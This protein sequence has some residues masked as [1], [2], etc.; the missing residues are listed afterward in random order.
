M[1]I[2]ARPGH[3]QARFTLPVAGFTPAIYAQ[4]ETVYRITSRDEHF[5]L[6]T[7][8]SQKIVAE[9]ASGANR[10]VT[11]R[12]AAGEALPAETRA[13]LDAA[14]Q[15]TR[16]LN[17]TEPSVRAL[18]ARF[19]GNGSAIDAIETFVDGYITN[20]TTGIPLAT[21]SG[22]IASR[23]GDCTEHAVLAI[24][25][26]RGIGIPARGV[27]GMILAP[28]FM[29]EENVF[30]YHM[31][32]EAY[33]QGR[34]VL[35]DATRPGKKPLNRYVAFAYH[36]LKSELPVPVLKA[37]AAIREMTVTYVSGR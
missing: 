9:T 32:A 6:I 29:G 26:L 23:A 18:T 4:Q 10:M 19:T 11:V 20:K 7:T 3:G 25:L 36:H 35:V 17:L 1:A 30:V 28:E 31:W 15:D 24:A 34:W 14:L 21:A 16:F 22:I 12:C 27:V 33:V 8:P 2:L 37:M 13:N 5:S